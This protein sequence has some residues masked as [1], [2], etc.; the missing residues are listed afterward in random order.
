[1]RR[2]LENSDPERTLY[3]D[4][5][6]EQSGSGWALV[7]PDDDEPVFRLY[8]EAKTEAEAAGL[9]EHYADLIRSY[10]REDK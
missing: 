9:I 2:L 10:E 7:V 5:I 1:M 4:G 6:K 8:S 3:F